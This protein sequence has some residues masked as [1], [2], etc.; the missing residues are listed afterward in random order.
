[1]NKVFS[2]LLILVFSWG[3]L[4]SQDNPKIRTKKITDNLY[5]IN[6]AGVN[7]IILT[8]SD[9][10][11]LVDNNT[12][13]AAPFL[14]KEIISIN[15]DSI[16][17]IV[18]TH[19]HFDHTE[20]NLVFGKGKTI[21]AHEDAKT[22]LSRDEMLLG[23][24]HKAYP[25]FA[26]PNKLI[27]DKYEFNLNGETVVI[28]SLSGGHSAGDIIV[29]FKNADVLHIGD[30]VFADMF[31]FVD[32]DHGGNAIKLS[33][34]IKTITDMFTSNTRIIPG[35]GRMLTTQDLK[36]YRDMI[37]GT[38]EIVKNEISKNKSLAEIKE[39]KVLQ[40]Y[41][42]WQAAF[43]FDDWIEILYASIKQK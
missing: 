2:T 7:S 38:I 31:P 1:M 36:E 23:D 17:I 33:E 9:G 39:S 22:L 26:L 5:L 10:T 16:N 13:S 40:S 42:E 19:W 24:L 34:N 18:N 6:A 21:I 43:N 3:I 20:G 12:Q 4:F 29:Y 37:N 27:K 8:G 25:D 32:T 15:K 41:A 11:L 35:H 30:I 14:L 28:T